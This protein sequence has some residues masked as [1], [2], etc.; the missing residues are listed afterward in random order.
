MYWRPWRWNVDGWIGAWLGAVLA[1]ALADAGWWIHQPTAV[2]VGL[3]GVPVGALVGGRYAQAIVAGGSRIGLGLRAGLVACLVAAGA[4]LLFSVV[5]SLFQPAGAV[6]N[7]LVYLLYVVLVI[8]G[9]VGMV[10]MPFALPIGVLGAVLIR[11]I[12]GKGG[13]GVAAL[14][15]TTIGLLASSAVGLARAG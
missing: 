1:G 9:V 10:G 11:E 7:R 8:P 15:V 12:H 3:V 6:P 5:A 14:G 2:V 4:W 13:L